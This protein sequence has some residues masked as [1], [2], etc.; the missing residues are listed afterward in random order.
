MTSKLQ[1]IVGLGNPGP[2]YQHT[3]HNAGA[4]FLAHLAEHGDSARHDTGA[5]FLRGLLSKGPA[6]TLRPER[7]FLGEYGKINIAGQDLHCLIPT[8]FM[9]NSG[10]AVKALASFYKI[11]ADAI[12]VAHDELDL[13]AGTAKFK[14]GGGHGGHNGLRDIISHLGSNDFYRLRIGIGHPGNS[15]QVIDYVLKQASVA[16]KQLI[17]QTLDEAIRVLPELLA[18]NWN[19]AQTKMNGF[20]AD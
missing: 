3:R 17:S 9:N 10:Q 4:E 16:D 18:G 14:R 8:T 2:K 7:K 1:L 12:L 19:K 15:K 5:G 13:P 6:N 20:K 11:P